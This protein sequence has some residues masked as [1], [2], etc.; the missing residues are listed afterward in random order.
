M[1]CFFT[2][3]ALDG[4]GL[5]LAYRKGDLLECYPL[6]KIPTKCAQHL[7]MVAVPDMEVSEGELLC[8]PMMSYDIVSGDTIMTERRRYFAAENIEPENAAAFAESVTNRTPYYTTRL[9]FLSYA[10]NDRVP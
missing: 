9:D 3:F 4:T 8:V 2:I 1:G 6:E 7:L 5:P 10:V